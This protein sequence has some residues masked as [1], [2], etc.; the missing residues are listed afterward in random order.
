[1]IEFCLVPELS[2]TS[3]QTILKDRMRGVIEWIISVDSG[4]SPWKAG[5]CGS[6][7]HQDEERKRNDEVIQDMTDPLAGTSETK[8]TVRTT[9]TLAP[10]VE[11]SNVQAVFCPESNSTRR[12]TDPQKSTGT[13]W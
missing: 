13:K 6:L 1:M 10:Q 4:C 9:E 12:P 11:R 8:E 5:S 3:E 2:E 7:R